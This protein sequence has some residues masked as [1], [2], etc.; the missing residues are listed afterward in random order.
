MSTRQHTAGKDGD[1]VIHPVDD[2]YLRFKETLES[3]GTQPFNTDPFARKLMTSVVDLIVNPSVSSIH[4][5]VKA[6]TTNRSS[7]ID[8]LETVIG[9]DH[10]MRDLVR[11]H[12]QDGCHVRN[13]TIPHDKIAIVFHLEPIRSQHEI[14]FEGY[15]ETCRGSGEFIHPEIDRQ[16]RYWRS[17]RT[18]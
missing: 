8:L 1:I 11:G 15:L 17:V 10:E 16:L 7:Y 3:H 14:G 4:E 12:Y 9:F 6:R 2:W 5:I 18:S 13:A